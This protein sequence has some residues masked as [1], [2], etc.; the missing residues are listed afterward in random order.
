[1]PCLTPCAVFL[2]VLLVV[3]VVSYSATK[4]WGRG[5]GLA[6][7]ACQLG[8]FDN[9]PSTDPWSEGLSYTSKAPSYQTAL[10]A[11]MQAKARRAASEG[12]I[13]RETATKPIDHRQFASQRENFSY[14]FI[15]PG[16][17]NAAL[18]PATAASPFVGSL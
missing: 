8:A 1:M 14:D 4:A 15:I 16:S 5:F 18:Q 6:Y 11:A 12:F 2:L 17:Q 7:E 3:F 9:L 13:Y 10:D